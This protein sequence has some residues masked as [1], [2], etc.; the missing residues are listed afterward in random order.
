[1]N[2]DARVEVGWQ[3]HPKTRRLL[4][5]IGPQG[6]L[7][8]V[9]LW[10]W[11]A[12]N[13]P[14]GR[15]S[16]LSDSEIEDLCGWRGE[17][18]AWVKAAVASGFLERH[19]SGSL[20]IHDWDE[21][22]GWVIHAPDR[23]KKAKKAAAA[24][25]DAR[26]RASSNAP[27]NARSNAPSPSPSPSPSPTDNSVGETP[28]PPLASKLA[29]AGRPSRSNGTKPP[30]QWAAWFATEFWPRYPRKV[31][32]Q[33]AMKA[34][35]KLKPRQPDRVKSAAELILTMLEKR[36]SDEWAGRDSDKIPHAATFLNREAFDA[37]EVLAGLEKS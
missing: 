33:A 9:W 36:K 16:D 32:K 22:Q 6:P 30:D 20:L 35:T 7:S 37:G 15:I 8:L 28:T 34:W 27:S 4:H 24:R 31:A 18:G 21:H 11:C 5:L 17:P 19:P 13:R 3:H 1:V 2:S 10:C 23:S 12:A 25:W 26:H 29:G 14:R